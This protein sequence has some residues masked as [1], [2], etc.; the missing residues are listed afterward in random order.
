[1]YLRISGGQPLLQDPAGFEPMPDRGLE[2]LG[3]EETRPRRLDRWRTIDGDYVK[4]LLRPFQV[5]AAVV[6]FDVG[7]R[8]IQDLRCIGMEVR[9]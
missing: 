7:Q 9:E 4:L 1:M 2:L 8:R 5:A 3:V 6:D